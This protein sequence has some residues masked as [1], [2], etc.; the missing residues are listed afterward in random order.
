MLKTKSDIRKEVRTRKSEFSPLLF[1]EESKYVC[2]AL[3]QFCN[4]NDKV[5]RIVAFWPMKDE[6]DIRPFLNDLYLSNT[7]KIYLP[8]ITGDG[9]MEFRLFEGKQN[10]AQEPQFGIWEPTSS[11]TLSP[12]NITAKD[13]IIIVVPGVA[14]TPNGDRLGRGRGFYDRILASFPSA[15]TVGVCLSCQLYDEL[16]T[17][18]HDKKIENIIASNIR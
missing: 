15:I 17:D 2:D 7:H 18:S 4:A 11:I 6:V 5:T 16:P 10:M 13:N 3:Y 9:I 1:S 12:N 8:V 14:F